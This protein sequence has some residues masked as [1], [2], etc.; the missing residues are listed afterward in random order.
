MDVAPPYKRLAL[1]ALITLFLLHT[2]LK[3]LTLFKQL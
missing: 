1:P 3:L 2:L